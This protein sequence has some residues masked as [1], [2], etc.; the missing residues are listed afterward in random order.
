E[1]RRQRPGEPNAI[2][3]HLVDLRVAALVPSA[4]PRR[5]A[6]LDLLLGEILIAVGAVQWPARDRSHRSFISPGS[7]WKR[8]MLAA[9]SAAGAPGGSGVPGAA[10]GSAGSGATKQA[11]QPG[12]GRTSTVTVSRCSGVTSC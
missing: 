5:A 4:Q 12:P 9:P 7:G 10:G 8:R 1:G 11:S 6:E 2:P 3:Q